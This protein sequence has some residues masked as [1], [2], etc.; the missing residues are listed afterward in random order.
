L[1]ASA[2]RLAHLWRVTVSVD[3]EDVERRVRVLVVDDE[4]TVRSFATQTM[5]LAGCDVSEAEHGDAALKIVSDRGSFDV[6]IVDLMMPA[7]RGDELARRLRQSDPDLKVLY[8]TGY[9]DRLFA[10]KNVLWENEAF[11]EKPVT[12]KGLQQAVS[13][14]LF[15]HT[16][17]FAS[18]AP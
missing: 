17:G 11:L 18:T 1:A 10:E 16:R 3:T 15:G 4:E 5:R 12:V 7:M 9:A 13:L 8:F 14:L 2:N 6:A